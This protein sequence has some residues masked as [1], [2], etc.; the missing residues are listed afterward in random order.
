MKAIICF[1]LHIF[2]S[3]V[4]PFDSCFYIKR[5][6]QII[7]LLMKSLKIVFVQNLILLTIVTTLS[8]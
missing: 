1:Y 8:Y 5:N 7:N 2:I 3:E 6:K 4:Q